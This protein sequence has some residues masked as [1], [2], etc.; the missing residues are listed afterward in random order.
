MPYNPYAPGGPLHRDVSA[1]IIGR[2]LGKVVQDAQDAARSRRERASALAPA[3]LEVTLQSVTDRGHR[4]RTPDGE[5][6]VVRRN[7]P[8]AEYAYAVFPCGPRGGVTGSL[9]GEGDSVDSALA[10]AGLKAV[11]G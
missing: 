9:L 6:V 10:A 8:A 4:Y 1:T 2:R 3:E 11:E 7:G 5:G